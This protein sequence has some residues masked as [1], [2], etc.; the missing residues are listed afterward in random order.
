[1]L[2][3]ASNYHLRMLSPVLQSNLINSNWRL[4]SFYS[5]SIPTDSKA[6]FKTPISWLWALTTIPGMLCVT[7]ITP[8]RID[9][10]I[11]NYNFRLVLSL[12]KYFWI[13]HR[14]QA[15]RF[16]SLPK[17]HRLTFPESAQ[18]QPSGPMDPP[19]RVGPLHLTILL[20]PVDE[21]D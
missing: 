20:T 19:H 8:L 9:F 10:N 18:S 11:C 12:T 14:P 1:M 2:P 17:L 21:R 3:G 15:L 5:P 7:L 6:F 13:M 16:F 4:V